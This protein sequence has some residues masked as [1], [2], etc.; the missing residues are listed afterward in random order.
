[1]NSPR[2]RRRLMDGAENPN[3]ETASQQ[4]PPGGVERRERV[5]T[6]AY[7]NAERRGFQSGGEVDDWLEAEKQIDDL[8]ATDKRPSELEKQIGSPDHMVAREPLPK[9]RPH[10]PVPGRQKPGGSRQPER[11]KASR[12]R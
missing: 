5:A 2:Q 12:A 6:A 3:A 4:G 1:M 11:R 10:D 7:Y 9:G 8:D